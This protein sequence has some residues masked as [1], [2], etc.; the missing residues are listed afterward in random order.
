MNMKPTKTFL[1]DWLKNKIDTKNYV[2][3]TYTYIYI[4]YTAYICIQHQSQSCLY[5]SKQAAWLFYCSHGQLGV[6][7]VSLFFGRND[8][9]HNCLTCQTRIKHNYYPKIH[10]ICNLHRF[11]YDQDSWTISHKQKNMNI[12]INIIIIILRSG[13]PFFHKFLT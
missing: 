1:N 12:N 3:H 8:G 13:R 5:K 2:L 4:M 6:S 7:L 9:T 11:L 10:L